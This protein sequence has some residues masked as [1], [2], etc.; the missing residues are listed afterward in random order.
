[1]SDQKT[2]L[3]NAII[4]FIF[5]LLVLLAGADKP[6]PIGFLWIVLVIALSALVV[7]WRIP[8]YVQW[9]QT[10]QPLRLLRVA[11]EGFVAGLVVAL[12]FALRGSGEP[13]VT[14]QPIDYVGWFVVLGMMGM[15]NSLAL[16]VINAVVARRL[17]SDEP[18]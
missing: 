12:P 1:M 18:A 3:I 10:Q 9:S 16:Y 15:L 11:L 4:F 17:D 8:T 13:S 14:M 7:Y 2:A 6:P 5:W